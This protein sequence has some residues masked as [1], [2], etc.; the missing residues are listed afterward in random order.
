MI[1]LHASLTIE[2]VEKKRQEM[3][4]LALNYGYTHH[5]TVQAS[6]ELDLILHSVTEKYYRREHR[7]S[8]RQAD[9]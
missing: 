1:I 7:N 5:L 8:I 3:I 2:I 4:T 9:S 6:R